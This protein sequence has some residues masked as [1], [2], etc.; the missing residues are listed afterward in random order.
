MCGEPIAGRY[1][2]R[3]EPDA[4][5]SARPGLCGG[6]WETSVPTAIS[7]W[8]AGVLSANAWYQELTQGSDKSHPVCSATR[9]AV[10]L[11]QEKTALRKGGTIDSEWSLLSALPTGS[12]LVFRSDRRPEYKEWPRGIR[13]LP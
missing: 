7:K 3:E 4:L 10:S 13:R 11:V 8:L 9:S 2:P 6:H 12:G 5:M 1:H